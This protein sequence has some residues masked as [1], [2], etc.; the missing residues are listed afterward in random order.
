MASK[1]SLTEDEFRLLTW[2]RRSLARMSI[3]PRSLERCCPLDNGR[4]ATTESIASVSSIGNLEILPIEI[5]HSIF[6]ILDLQTLTHCRAISW[7]ARCLVDSIPPY[8]T[9]VQHA[10]NALRALL[11]TNMA[12]CFTAQD[13]FKALCMQDCF[14]CGQFGPFLDLFS[15]QRCCVTCIAYSDALLSIKTMPAKNTHIL[16]PKTMHIFTTI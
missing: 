6:N 10:P 3:Q 11:S 4:H 15:A 14:I 1:I 2:S 8:K 12:V 7:R 5:I 13:I 16:N 9:I